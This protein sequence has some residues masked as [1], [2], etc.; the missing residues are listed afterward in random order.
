[1]KVRK[2]A[3]ALLVPALLALS[4]TAAAPA[5]A[6]DSPNEQ[7]VTQKADG[8]VVITLLVYGEDECPQTNGDD[9]VVCARRPEAERYRIPPKLRQKADDFSGDRGSWTSH[10]EALEAS[11]RFTRP[12]S[13]S[14]VGTGGQTGCLAA[15]LHQWYLEKQMDKKGK[16]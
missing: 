13:C 6:Q 11:T 14:T 1:M 15:A 16:K 9:I 2:S 7:S 3:L 4:L 12:N 5:L 10:N 8:T